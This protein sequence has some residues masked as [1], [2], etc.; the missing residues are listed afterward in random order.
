MDDLTC[1]IAG[2]EFFVKDL[3]A[4]NRVVQCLDWVLHP[5]VGC[6]DSDALLRHRPSLQANII[7]AYVNEAPL[8]FCL[9]PS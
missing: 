2:T 4:A 6:P 1:L 8:T 9:F 7:A 3:A 5:Q